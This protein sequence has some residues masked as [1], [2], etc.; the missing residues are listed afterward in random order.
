MFES[1]LVSSLT[2]VNIHLKSLIL[3]LKG[4]VHPKINIQSSS[5]PPDDIKSSSPPPDDGLELQSKIAL[6]RSAKHL[7]ELET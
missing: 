2:E 7:K 1:S 6:Q 3:S 4:K 5:P